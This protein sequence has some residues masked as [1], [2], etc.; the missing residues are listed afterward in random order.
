MKKI[1]LLCM[2]LALPLSQ[3]FAADSAGNRKN[4]MIGVYGS[5]GLHIPSL[6][7]PPV[8][9]QLY[10]G[11]LTLAYE[12]GSGSGSQ[13]DGN[14]TS[15][16]TYDN[17]GIVARYFLG[18]SFNIMG[19]YHNR[20]WTADA[21][22]TQYY[23]GIPATAQAKVESQA[24]VASLGIGNHWLTDFGLTIGVDWFLGSAIIDSSSKIEVGTNTGINTDQVARDLTEF[25][26]FLNLVSATPGLFVVSVGFA[27]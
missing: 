16:V 3:A 24:N 5:S 22:V 20:K 19:A 7:A 4:T 6:L 18:N 26:E 14:S 25:S 13:D 11:D 12:N 15:T 1:F 27:F 2:A 23:Y 10:L 21:T 17:S 9:V 8:G